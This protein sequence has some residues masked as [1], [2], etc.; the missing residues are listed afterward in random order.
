MLMCPGGAWWKRTARNI[1]PKEKRPWNP[2]GKTGDQGEYVLNE[3]RIHYRKGKK[4]TSHN[5][6]G[7]VEVKGK[8]RVQKNGNSI[9]RRRNGM[10]SRRK[11]AK[12]DVTKHREK[13]GKSLGSTGAPGPGGKR[14]NSFSNIQT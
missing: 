5:R 6:K 14:R 2:R 13:K 11:S 10:P 3:R 1:A 4:K 7:G 12:F 8:S 9:S